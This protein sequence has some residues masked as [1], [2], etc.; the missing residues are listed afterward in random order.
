MTNNEVTPL[1]DDD[2]TCSVKLS[3]PLF[4]HHDTVLS[5]LEPVIIS[6]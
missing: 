4:S 6:M 1:I 3:E 2:I 5:V